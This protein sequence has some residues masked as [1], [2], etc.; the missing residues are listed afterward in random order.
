MPVYRKEGEQNALN[1]KAGKFS[2][3]VGYEYEEYIKSKNPSV[4]A[5]VIKPETKRTV[6]VEEDDDE[7]EPLDFH[8][9]SE[10]I[11]SSLVGF[12]SKDAS[13]DNDT[14]VKET[15]VVDDYMGEDDE[16]SIM[17]EINLNIKSSLAEQCSQA[18]LHLYQ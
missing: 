10:K 5:H 1:V 4:I 13:D 18:D 9:A 7:V 12:F 2:E 17:Q 15:E 6:I 14:P 11:M 3:V 8:S 16:K